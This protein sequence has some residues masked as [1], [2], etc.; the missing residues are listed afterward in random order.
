MTLLQNC[1]SELLVF[2]HIYRQIQHGKESSILLVTGQEVTRPYCAPRPT[3]TNHALPEFWA[4]KRSQASSGLALD[5]AEYQPFFPSFAG[6]PPARPPS[7][8]P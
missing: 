6:C 2:V 4:Q 5:T 8:Q 7:D 3:P 1:W